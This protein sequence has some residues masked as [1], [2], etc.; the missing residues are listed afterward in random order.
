VNVTS[1]MLSA[2]VVVAYVMYTLSEDVISRVG[3]P[4]VYVTSLF[5]VLGIMRYLQL[6]LVYENT[7][8]PTKIL[9]KDNPIRLLV[10]SWIIT[11]GIFLYL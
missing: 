4:N 6:A 1:V 11:F 2:V 10:L 5:V 8:S 3:N 7:G 9:L